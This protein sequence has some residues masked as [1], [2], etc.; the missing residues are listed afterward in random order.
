MEL[1]LLIA[2]AYKRIDGVGIYILNHG[3]TESQRSEAIQT[4]QIS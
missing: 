3:N 1:D 2:D 4:I